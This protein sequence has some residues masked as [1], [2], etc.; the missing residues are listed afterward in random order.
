MR[1][2]WVESRKN[3]AIKTQLHYAKRGIMTQEM[4]YVANIEHL[5]A[6]VVRKEVAKGRLILPANVNHTNLEPM[7][8]GIATRTKIN[9]NIGSSALAS[10]IDEEVQKTLISIKY[11]ADT[12]MDLS[13]GGDLDSIRE[14]VIQ[15]SSVPIGTVPIYQ[16]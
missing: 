13:T 6:E 11:G 14:A 3:D 5:D 9:A 1:S 10:S 12:I 8:I 4:E 2:K 16:I 7:G 15:N